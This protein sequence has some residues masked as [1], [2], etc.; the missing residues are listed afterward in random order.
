[1]ARIVDVQLADE[2]GTP[3]DTFEVNKQVRLRVCALVQAPI[4]R[5]GAA[6]LLRDQNGVDL[7]G[8]TSH[9]YGSTVERP[10][11]GQEVVFTFSFSNVLKFG[12]YSLSVA[13]NRLAEPGNPV[14]GILIHQLDNVAGYTSTGL[15]DMELYMPVYVPVSVEVSRAEGDGRGV[16]EEGG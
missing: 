5:F 10:S 16:L 14:S 9:H 4:E 8:T 7:I 12:H 3:C 11:V 2:T 6:F 1:L 13:L 15:A